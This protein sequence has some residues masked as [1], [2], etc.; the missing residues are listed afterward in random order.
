MRDLATKELW[1]GSIPL[2]RVILVVLVLGTLPGAGAAWVLSNEIRDQAHRQLLTS[3][4]QLRE[5]CRRSN[6][7]RRLFNQRADAVAQLQEGVISFM[8]DARDARRGRGPAH[9]P[10]LADRYQRDISKVAAVANEHLPLVNCDKA[11]R[12][13][14]SSRGGPRATTA[15]I[16]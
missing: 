15:A 4:T 6:H 2:W 11:F 10:A 5:G 3:Q 9:D 1:C 14:Q 16:R 8:V 12:F 13:V 7:F